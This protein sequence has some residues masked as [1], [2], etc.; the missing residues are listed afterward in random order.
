MSFLRDEMTDKTSPIIPLLV[1]TSAIGSFVGMDAL[2][3]ELSTE[4]SAYN[5]M[6]WRLPVTLPLAF[7]LLIRKRRTKP[8]RQALRL[9]IGRGVL[10]TCMGFLFF[11][12][13]VLVPLAESIALSFIAPLIALFLAAVLLKEHVDLITVIASGIGFV[14]VIVV[15]GGQLGGHYGESVVIGISAILLSALMYAYN[16]VLQRQQALLAAPAEIAFYQNLTV[17]A[18][19]LL[20]APIWADLPPT[21]AIPKLAIAAA[22][23]VLS[24]MMMSWAYA[25]AETKVLL[26]VEY[27]AFVWAVLFGWLLFGETLTLITLLGTALIVS[28]CLLTARRKAERVGSSTA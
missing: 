15:I 20:V 19:L 14:G 10:V 22:L 26:P 5:A 28:G 3:K 21:H 1:A 4:L 7:A 24:M 16:L 2:M 9:H 17:A 11:W 25:R 27:T 18:C 8:S 12:G 23:S 13:L 6:L